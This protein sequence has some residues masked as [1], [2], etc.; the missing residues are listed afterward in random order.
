MSPRFPF[1]TYAAHL[2]HQS[3]RDYFAM[4]AMA[5]R[6]SAPHEVF[7]DARKS[8]RARLRQAEAR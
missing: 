2:S 8:K 4:K 1:A 7:R 6:G 3:E 5:F